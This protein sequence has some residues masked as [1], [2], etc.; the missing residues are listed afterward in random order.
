[1][2][3]LIYGVLGVPVFGTLFAGLAV[4]F[5]HVG[6]W[7]C[8]KSPSMPKPMRGKRAALVGLI[9]GYLSLFTTPL[10]LISLGIGAWANKDEVITV[11]NQRYTEERQNRSFDAAARLYLA[12]ETYASSHDE[13]YPA[14]WD[15]LAGRYLTRNDLER[16][17]KS[18]H[19]DGPAESFQMVPHERPVLRA[20]MDTVVVI[21]EIAPPSVAEIVVVYADGNTDLIANPEVE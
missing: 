20:I 15:E 6:M 11:V 10:I 4:I 5:G 12:C 21:Q 16:L 14:S 3:S 17:L 13:Q 2:C 1:M 9:L 18:S 7:K 19:P 8:Q